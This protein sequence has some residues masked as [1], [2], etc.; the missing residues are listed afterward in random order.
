M[1][2]PDLACAALVDAKTAA[3][4]GGMGLS[5]WFDEVRAGR[6]PQ[7]AVRAPRCTRWRVVDVRAFWQRF[8]EQGADARALAQATKASKAAKAA[9]A[10]QAA[11]QAG[12]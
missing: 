1:L 3:A 8:A 2:P 9:K 4:V 6:A 11:A 7:P 12:A 5:W 10:A